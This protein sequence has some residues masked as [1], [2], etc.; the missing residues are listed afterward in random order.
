MKKQK[1]PADLT[2]EALARNITRGYLWDP[3]LAEALKRLRAIP[4]VHP[5]MDDETFDPAFCRH[6]AILSAALFEF[7]KFGDKSGRSLPEVNIAR[8]LM[9]YIEELSS[10]VSLPDEQERLEAQATMAVGKYLAATA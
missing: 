3:H 6:A 4:K 10:S 8:G 1:P 5:S 9:D 7:I 2:N